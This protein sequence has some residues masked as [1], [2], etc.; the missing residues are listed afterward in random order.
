MSNIVEQKKGIQSRHTYPE[1]GASNTGRGQP[2]LQSCRKAA[3]T[4]PRGK[5][6]QERD[7]AHDN[8]SLNSIDNPCSGQAA[9]CGIQY[10]VEIGGQRYAGASCHS[11]PTSNIQQAHLQQRR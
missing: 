11:I 10:F 2:E 3:I 7:T 1:L 9:V 5:S 6:Y 4:I 8:K